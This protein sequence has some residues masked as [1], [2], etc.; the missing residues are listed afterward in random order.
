[1]E[2][3]EILKLKKGNII[4]HKRGEEGP[5]QYSGWNNGNIWEF[6]EES[7]KDE[8]DMDGFFDENN[9]IFLTTSELKGFKL[10]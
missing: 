4:G 7:F 6:Y 9:R 3:N 5:Y 8:N 1:M 2:Y 10:L